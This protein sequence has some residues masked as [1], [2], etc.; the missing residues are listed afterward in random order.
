MKAWLQKARKAESKERAERREATPGDVQERSETERVEVAE[1]EVE[2]KG[3]KHQ[4]GRKRRNSYEEFMECPSYYFIWG[5]GGWGRL[6][7]GLDLDWVTDEPE[8]VQGKDQ[9]LRGK[10][11]SRITCQKQHTFILTGTNSVKIYF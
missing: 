8:P 3:V 4:R 9:Q 6:G 11:I 5:A 2:E 7:L 10:Q 1:K